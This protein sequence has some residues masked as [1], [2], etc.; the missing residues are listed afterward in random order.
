MTVPRNNR[1]PGDVLAESC[2]LAT[3]IL[4][5]THFTDVKTEA[6]GSE[7]MPLRPQ[8]QWVIERGFGTRGLGSPRLSTAP[9][10][11]HATCS[12]GPEPALGMPVPSLAP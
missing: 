11:E 8:S 5:Q 9:Q 4:M 6:Q 12:Q 1:D 10:N 2:A 7:A 3:F